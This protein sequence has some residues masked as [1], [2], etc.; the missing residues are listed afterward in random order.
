MSPK[1]RQKGS[2]SL[3]KRSNGVWVATVDLPSTD[4]KRRQKQMTSTDRNEALRKLRELQAMVAAGLVPGAGNV[5][6]E[7]WMD[8]WLKSVH[9]PNVKPTTIKSYSNTI[10]LYINPCLGHKRLDR[11][12]PEDVRQMHR[13]LQEKSTS[14]AAKAHQVLRRALKDAVND[15]LIVRNVADV[16]PRPKHLKAERQAFDFDTAMKLIKAAFASRDEM[17]G[18]RWAVGFLTG[19]RQGEVLGLQWDRV[20]FEENQLDFAWQLQILPMVHGCGEPLDEVYPCGR[21]MESYCPSAHFDFPVGFP[22]H[23]LKGPL[24]LTRPKTRGSIRGVP[25]AP[26]LYAAMLALKARDGDNPHNLVF[27]TPSGDPIAPSA[28]H[29]EWKALLAQVE[30]DA[31]PLHSMRHSIATMMMKNKTGDKVIQSILGHSAVLTTQ[32][33]QHADDPMALAAVTLLDG[34][35]G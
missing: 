18:V 30:L 24:V 14:N 2:G 32:G 1:R 23:V 5:K 16:V 29:K 3:F 6:V 9:G 25:M 35:L 17:W 33:Y 34:L 7:V 10:R 20:D 15:G 26:N 4:G 27:H 22:H 31:A 8:H 21:I 11:L 28:D 12:T 19:A 13:T